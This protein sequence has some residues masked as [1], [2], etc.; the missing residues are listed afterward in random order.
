MI[1]QEICRLSEELAGNGHARTSFDALGLAYPEALAAQVLAG[2]KET[3]Q[4]AA[5]HDGRTGMLMFRDNEALMELGKQI[6]LPIVDRLFGGRK[7]VLDEVGMYAI[8]QYEAGEFFRPHQDHFDGTVM[9]ATIAGARKFDVYHKEPDDDV[10]R[11]VD[12]SYEHLDVGSIVMLN[13][14]KNLGHAA[15][16]I[17]GPSVSVVSDVPFP[18]TVQ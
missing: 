2:F 16:C 11:T 17:E 5:E 12:Y 3:E 6:I 1:T 18:L 13:G 9:I 14:Y 4:F 10:F 7:E 8:N 15:Q